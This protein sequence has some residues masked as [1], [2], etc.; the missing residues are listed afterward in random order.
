VLSQTYLPHH[1]E[2]FGT[3]K[4]NELGIS[5]DWDGW[6]PWSSAAI[7]SFVPCPVQLRHLDHAAERF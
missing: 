3:G 6:K 2:W 7:L 4:N 1:G 5:V